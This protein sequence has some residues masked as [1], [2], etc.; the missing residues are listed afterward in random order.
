MCGCAGSYAY[1]AATRC[2]GG[3]DR[4]YPVGA[5]EISD[6]QVVRVLRLVQAHEAS[7]EYGDEGEYVALDLGTKTYTVYLRSDARIAI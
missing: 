2:E 3:E 6:R 5:D 1:R 4:G 7:V